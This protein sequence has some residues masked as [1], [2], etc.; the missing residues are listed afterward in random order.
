MILVF[1]SKIFPVRQLGVYPTISVANST[2]RSPPK[3][4]A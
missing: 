2:W 4:E 3:P 1:S